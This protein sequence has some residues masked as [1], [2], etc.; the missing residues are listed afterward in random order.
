MT[1]MFVSLLVPLLFLGCANDDIYDLIHKNQLSLQKLKIG[2]T[3]A[4]AMDTMGTRSADTRR[5]AI[6]NPIRTETFADKSGTQH[7]VL[8]YVTQRSRN[9]RETMPLVFRNGV[10]VGWGLNALTQAQSGR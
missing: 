4:E 9:Y 8:H 5:G 7:E 3:K 1:R 10:L 6:A 2:M